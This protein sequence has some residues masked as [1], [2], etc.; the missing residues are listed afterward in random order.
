MTKQALRHTPT[1]R[2]RS[3]AQAVQRSPHGANPVRDRRQ[4]G[5]RSGMLR[6]MRGAMPWKTILVPY[7]FSAS[8]EHALAI[9][10]AEA[11]HH[12]AAVL[13]LHVVELMPLFGPD[14]TLVLP[15][16]AATPL[17]VHQYARQRANAD[18]RDAVARQRAGDA[19][20]LPELS[21]EI[22]VREGAPVHEI[23]DFARQ[24]DADVIVMGT[25]GRTGLRRLVAGSVA[26]RLVRTSPVPVLTIRHPDPG[27]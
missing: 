17:G 10:V 14:T 21:I 8:A 1:T 19:P 4:A 20:G 2:G 13:V 5:A 15:E 25:H 7:D 23:L 9:A 12:R 26:E 24:E 22:F 3:P 16:G 6:A 11:R 18:L 27:D